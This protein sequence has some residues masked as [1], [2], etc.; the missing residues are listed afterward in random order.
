[1]DYQPQFLDIVTAIDSLRVF[2]DT[3]TQFTVLLK[4]RYERE[5]SPKELQWIDELCGD[6]HDNCHNYVQFIKQVIAE[7]FLAKCLTLEEDAERRELIKEF[8]AN[9]RAANR[10]LD[11]FMGRE[12]NREEVLGKVDGVLS[13]MEEVQKKK[14]KK[15]KYYLKFSEWLKGKVLEQ[16]SEVFAKVIS[17]LWD[18]VYTNATL[19]VQSNYDHETLKSAVLK[20]GE[21]VPEME[22]SLDQNRRALEG[23]NSVLK[24]LEGEDEASLKTAMRRLSPIQTKIKN[25]CDKM[26]KLLS[27]LKS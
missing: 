1:M 26:L 6:Y 12:T 10:R 8:K 5:H 2:D 24:V 22:E 23:I 27:N 14:D 17:P 13:E 19:A 11:N 21:N 18:M 9:I 20:I 16:V 3:I 7:R 25:S 15:A 4:Q